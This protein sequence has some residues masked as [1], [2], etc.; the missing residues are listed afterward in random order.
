[1]DKQRYSDLQWGAADRLTP[2]ELKE[3]WHWCAEMDDLLCV[4]GG[5]DC[6]CQLD[7]TRPRFWRRRKRPSHD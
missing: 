7:P 3:G 5:D 1:M 2:E 6:F 4:V